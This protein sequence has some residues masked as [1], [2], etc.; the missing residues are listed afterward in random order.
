V[1]EWLYAHSGGVIS[2]VVSLIHDAQE[3]AILN[4]TEELNQEMLNEAYQKRLA[5]LHSYIQPPPV[6]R[7]SA[8]AVRK[9]VRAVQKPIIESVSIEELAMKA[10]KDKLDMV[11]LLREY[12]P[13]DE[14]SI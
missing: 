14:V 4:G 9:Q 6:K 8:A 10:R 12:M 2:V 7:P 3:I 1:I 11:M 13:V 5:M